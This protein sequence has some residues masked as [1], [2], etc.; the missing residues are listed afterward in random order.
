LSVEADV[1]RR[2]RVTPVYSRPPALVSLSV[3]GNGPSA[4]GLLAVRPATFRGPFLPRHER[5]AAVRADFPCLGTAGEECELYADRPEEG[6]SEQLQL[7][8]VVSVGDRELH[9]G[10][11]QPSTDGVREHLVSIDPGSPGAE[12]RRSLSSQRPVGELL[13]GRSD[14]VTEAPSVHG[15]HIGQQPGQALP[16]LVCREAVRRLN[17]GSQTQEGGC[18]RGNGPPL[19][20]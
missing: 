3:S 7:G 8:V 1:S 19:I 14:A 9:I 18:R 4:F 13:G 2:S 12:L 16:G 10:E 17:R 6:A 15:R 5:L 20:D 11:F